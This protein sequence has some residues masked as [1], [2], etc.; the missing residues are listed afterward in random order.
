M[1]ETKKREKKDA[2]KLTRR[3]RTTAD[4][5]KT[6]T[7]RHSTRDCGGG[8]GR[9]DD[10]RVGTGVATTGDDRRYQFGGKISVTNVAGL[11]SASQTES[12]TACAFLATAAAAATTGAREYCNF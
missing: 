4:D 6:T 1:M 5:A 8:V 2:K 11:S 9:V 7:Q 10:E 12:S 3:R